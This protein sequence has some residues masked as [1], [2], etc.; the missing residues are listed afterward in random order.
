M[1][2]THTFK[3]IISPIIETWC[4]HVLNFIEHFKLIYINLTLDPKMRSACHKITK[5][6][7]IYRHFAHRF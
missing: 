1:I 6:N 2:I 4:S 3:L 5:G 7:N